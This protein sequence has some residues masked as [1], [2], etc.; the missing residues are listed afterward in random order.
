METMLKSKDSLVRQGGD[1]WRQKQAELDAQHSALNMK[2]NAFN[3]EIFAQRQ[4]LSER[5]NVLNA[6]QLE[7]EK[8]LAARMSEIQKLKVELTKAIAEYKSRK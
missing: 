5:E 4:T 2:I 3:E 6:Q 8:D 7:R 1:F